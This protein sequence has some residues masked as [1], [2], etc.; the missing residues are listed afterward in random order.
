M[1]KSVNKKVASDEKSSPDGMKS[2][3]DGEDFYPNKVPAGTPGTYQKRCAYHRFTLCGPLT[4]PLRA[5]G[6]HPG[7]VKG[8]PDDRKR[9]SPNMKIINKMSPA[10]RKVLATG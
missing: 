4:D 5:P 8:D 3:P 7:G 2:D 1:M 9:V 6:T 10:M